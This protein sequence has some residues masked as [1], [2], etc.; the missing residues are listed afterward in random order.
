MKAFQI[1]TALL[2]GAIGAAALSLTSAASAA[3]FVIGDVFASVGNGQVRQY[4]AAGVLKDTLSTGL[5]GF[6]TGSAF[7]SA[8][9]FFVTN[10]SNGSVSRFSGPG[11]PHVHSVFAA[12]INSAPES[13][14]FDLAG[15][16]YVG[17][18]DGNADINKYSSA[19]VLLDTFNV[20][21]TDRGSDWID[22]ARDQRTM[23]YTSEGNTIKRYD[24]VA[25]VQLADFATLPGRP[26]FALRLVGDGTLLVA[27]SAAIYRLNA[28]G[29]VIQTYDDAGNNSWFSLN[30]NNDGTSFWSGDF[31]TGELLRFDIA[32]GAVLQTIATGSGSL[33][34][35]SVFGEITEGGGGGGGTT[36]EP[37]SLLLFGIALAG[38]GFSARRRKH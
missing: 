21:T 38:L 30:L 9:N 2:A 33:F 36:P 17:S 37:A 4:S 12:G 26:A 19:G 18:A 13:I 6:T 35:V 28:L 22:L 5:G 20:A 24:V 23:F 11:D 8:G 27:D 7:D 16:M 10:F 14:V 1:R 15:N 3:P 32:T 29:N 25:D 34:G 31:S